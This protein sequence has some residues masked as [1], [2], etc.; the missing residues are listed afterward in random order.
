MHFFSH[1]PFNVRKV[2]GGNDLLKIAPSG[3]G[4]AG[5]VQAS[6]PWAFPLPN[7]VLREPFFPLYPRPSPLHLCVSTTTSRINLKTQGSQS[8]IK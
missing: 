1:F 7:A 6:P 5:T 8:I 3:K 2:K 4:R